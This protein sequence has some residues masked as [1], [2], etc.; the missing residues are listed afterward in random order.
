MTES[1]AY[2]CLHQRACIVTHISLLCQSATVMTHLLV[3]ARRRSGQI[4][5]QLPSPCHC[6]HYDGPPNRYAIAAL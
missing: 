4:R 3:I 5:Y 1:L 6:G 2:R